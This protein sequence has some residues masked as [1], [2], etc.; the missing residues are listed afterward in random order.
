MFLT[1][2]LLIFLR[3]HRILRNVCY[4][5][6]TRDWVVRSLLSILEKANEK[7]DPGNNFAIQVFLEVC[8]EDRMIIVTSYFK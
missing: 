1:F 3:L 5:G 6:P 2:I 8:S 4:H 7:A